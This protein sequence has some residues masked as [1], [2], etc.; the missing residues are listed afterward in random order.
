MKLIIQK[1]SKD[2]IKPIHSLLSSCGKFMFDKYNLCHWHPFMDLEAFINSMAE[3][4]L[5]SVYQENNLI[6]TFNLSLI[7]RNY[8]YDKLWSHPMMKA[9]Y[10]GQLGIDPQKQGHGIGKWCMEN[11]ET[12]SKQM[13]CK[14]IRFDALNMHPWLKIFYVTQGYAP[15]G[16][17]KP[18]EWDLLCFEKLLA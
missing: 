9:V 10:L 7:P 4:D 8:Y 13:G 14:Y 11:I 12:I 6:A 1:S 18:K 5:Y 15:R 2:E 3:K 17:V 16:I